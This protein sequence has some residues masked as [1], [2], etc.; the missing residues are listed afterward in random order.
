MEESLIY[1]RKNLI[2]KIFILREKKIRVAEI[3]IMEET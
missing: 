2:G 3:R 1:R